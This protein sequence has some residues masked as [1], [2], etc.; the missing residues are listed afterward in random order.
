MDEWFVSNIFLSP[1]IGEWKLICES[2]YECPN[3]Q[4]LCPENKEVMAL[5][6]SS[7]PVLYEKAADRFEKKMK[8]SELKRGSIDFSKQIAEAKKILSKAKI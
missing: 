1:V 7:V 5:A 8:A 4:H 2:F 6:I 3:K